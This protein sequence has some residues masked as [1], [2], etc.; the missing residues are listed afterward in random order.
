MDYY[1]MKAQILSLF[2][3]LLSISVLGQEIKPLAIPP[4]EQS[5]ERVKTAATLAEGYFERNGT[6]A[7]SVEISRRLLQEF[8]EKCDGLSEVPKKA[9]PLAIADCETASQLHLRQAAMKKFPVLTDK[10][11]TK[12]AE[13]AY[14]LYKVG[15]K[16]KVNYMG[17]P[18]YGT[19]VEGTYYG[20]QGGIVRVGKHRIRL[21]DMEGIEGNDVEMLK[22]NADAAGELRLKYIDKL[23]RNQDEARNFFLKEESEAFFTEE[24]KACAAQNEADG[25]TAF[26]G[27]WLKPSALL[28]AVVEQ[29]RGEYLQR[30]QKE[31]RHQLQAAA[32]S[33]GA[34]AESI[35]MRAMVFPA[36]QRLNPEKVLEAQKAEA[37]RKA[38]AEAKRKQDEETRRQQAEED[39][40]RQDEELEAR[41]QAATLAKKQMASSVTQEPGEEDKPLP[42][43]KIVIA[44]MILVFVL[45]IAVSFFVFKIKQKRDKDRFKRFFEGKGEIQRDFWAMADADPEHFKYVAYMFPTIKEATNALRKLTYISASPNGDLKCSKDILFGVYPH[46][47]GAVAFLGGANYHYAPWREATAVLPELP[48]AT[49]FKVSTEPEVMLDVP[50]IEKMAADKN[51]KIENLGVEDITN[52]D[53]GITR[54]YKYRTDSEKSAKIFLEDF[55]VNEEGI[56]IHVETPEGIFGR[57]ENGIFSV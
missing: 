5:I 57:D 53:G 29:T 27:S 10:E 35:M 45:A 37:K 9:S 55:Q 3:V 16:V 25:Y 38:E 1:G 49:Y 33:I 11:L 31:Q 26:G 17:N 39:A 41:K 50:D 12:L 4:G 15:E 30:K 7:S 42:F 51:L 8:L 2:V 40:K 36:N 24:L 52:P 14:P 48:G 34:Q 46:L 23:K 54:C 20:T 47:E 22:F 19:T 18:R 28:T 6:A 56:V 44:V 43:T 21:A 32:K 13:K